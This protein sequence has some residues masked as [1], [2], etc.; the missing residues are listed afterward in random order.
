MPQ[1]DPARS[2]AVLIGVNEYEQPL[3]HSL[4]SVAPG[5]R[6]L[7]ELLTDPTVW[8]LSE[9]H[10]VELP[11]PATS[12][13]VLKAVCAAARAATDTLLVYFAG[14]GHLI[15]GTDLRLMLPTAHPGALYGAVK[16]GDLRRVLLEERRA[17]NQVV[18]LDCCYS[19]AAVDE[20]MGGAEDFVDGVGVD[21]SYLMTSCAAQ[22]A[23]FAPRGEMYP[24]FTGALIRAIG[25]GVPGAPDPLPMRDLFV[26]VRRALNARG[27]PE[28]RDLATGVGHEIALVRNRGKDRPV[29]GDAPALPPP[30]WKR[31]LRRV[32]AT[33]A[34]AVTATSSA[35]LTPGNGVADGIPRDLRAVSRAVDYH[36]A[37]P[38]ALTD[39][40]G[41]GRFGRAG[42]DAAYGGFE[43]CDVLVEGEDGDEIDV[44]VGF[45]K[46]Q[47][48]PTRG[49]EKRD[50]ITVV[51]QPAES[52]RCVREL[53]PDG[54]DITV[55][56]LAKTG[57]STT[58]PLC[59]IADAATGHALTALRKGL[60]N[61]GLPARPETFPDDSL[62]RTDACALLNGAALEAV[63]GVDAAD[64]DAGFGNWSCTWWSPTGHLQVDL[65]F[66]RGQSP[67][68]GDG[69]PTSVQG[70]RA[71]VQPEADDENMCQVRVVQRTY[72]DG[73]DRP[74]AETLD[75][76]VRGD[77]NPSTDAL[78]ALANQLADASA[79]G[80]PPVG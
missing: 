25:R 23:S 74:L 52:D 51:K 29:P 50:G 47:E 39:P 54:D 65:R 42:Q 14:H 19:G 67:T 1:P 44:M 80:L 37:D 53:L 33:A 61:G 41:L 9:K 15:G 63:P 24:A 68:A 21:R 75:V 8:G 64:P 56:V 31:R 73:P 66:D 12:D 76:A 16:Y 55:T 3:L 77:E 58:A 79:S 49:V 32:A 45:D 62:F 48:P 7:A 70:R 57:G 35:H 20:R 46:G 17:E 60:E 72:S 5:V 30:G 36:D 38:C 40:A 71:F 10:C 22:E 26:H 69:T 43:R 18:I 11:N 6:R 34:I 2:R 13:E 59:E 78:C 27:L 28:P 4:P